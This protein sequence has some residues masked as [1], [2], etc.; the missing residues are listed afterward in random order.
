V[1]G[2]VHV[3]IK[4]LPQMPDELQHRY[5]LVGIDRAAR[6][7]YVEIRPEKSA[8]CAQGFLEHLL[9]AVPFKVTQVL[10]DNGKEFTDRFCAA[11]EREPTGCH[12]FDRTCAEQA[13]EPRLIQ[14]AR[15]QTHGRV[16]RFNGRIAEVLATTR[17]RSGE[18]LADTLT[19][20]VNT[21]NHHIP[22]RALGP[23]SPVQ[24]LQEWYEKEPQLF[25]QEV[26]NLPG[27]DSPQALTDATPTL[28]AGWAPAE[29][30]RQTLPRGA[31]TAF[32][33]S[34]LRLHQ[35][36]RGCGFRLQPLDL[37]ESDARTRT[38]Y[39]LITNHASAQKTPFASFRCRS[40]L[41]I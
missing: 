11:G 18:H 41:F 39:L 19:R 20:D 12:R 38:A 3:D 7:V 24:A 29:T 28:A 9:A 17:F 27:L 36:K 23:I 1:P 32:Q 33:P 15:P 6:W 13:V 10:T 4:Y 26:N 40:R 31:L 21:Y 30:A 22:P 25:H 35:R 5:L 2:F 8:A 16:E 37:F 14:P 34:T